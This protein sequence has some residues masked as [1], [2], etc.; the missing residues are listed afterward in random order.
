MSDSE[1]DVFS[2]ESETKEFKEREEACLAEWETLK[3]SNAERF[4]AKNPK[5]VFYDF[6][7]L[8]FVGWNEYVKKDLSDLKKLTIQLHDDFAVIRK[9]DMAVS[10][11][12]FDFT[13]FPKEGDPIPA[14]ARHTVLWMKKDESWLI[15]HE[16]YSSPQE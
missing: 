16:H 11:V 8:K 7:P 14:Q 1:S 12:T 5:L 3:P 9:G 4:Y 10:M 13:L 15:F 2:N 6:A